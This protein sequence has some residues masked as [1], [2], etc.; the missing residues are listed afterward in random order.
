MKD[1]MTDGRTDLNASLKAVRLFNT[2]EG[3]C[4]FELGRIPTSQPINVNFFFAQTHIDS[5]Q[6]VAHPAPR[7]QY[8]ITLKGKLRFKVTNGD[9]FIIEPGILL[10]AEDI[11]G[12]GHTWELVDG[13]EW[14]RLYIAFEEGTDTQFI[15]DIT[16]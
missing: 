9:T 15:P 1:L 5:Y 6:E 10:L 4:T 3:D 11:A 2:G 8:V 16:G 7:L 13:D 14:Q 12:P